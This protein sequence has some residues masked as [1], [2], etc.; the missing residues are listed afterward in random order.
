MSDQLSKDALEYHESYPA[1][2]L[3]IVATKPMETQRDLALAYSPGVAAAC[4]AIADN[5]DQAYRLTAK[6]NLVGVITNGSAVLGLGN[7]GALASKPVMEGKAVLFKKFSGIDVFD[8]E[9][10]QS[11]ADQFIETVASLEPTFGGINLEDIKAPECFE[12]ERALRERM[13]IPVFHDDQHGTAIVTTAAINSA[14]KLVNKNIEDVRLV[15]SGAGAAAL[16]CID[17]LIDLGLDRNKLLVLDKE[18]VVHSQRKTGIDKYKARYAIETSA[19]TMDD[20]I[21][22]ADIFLGCSAPGA[23]TG[24]QVAKMVEQ[25]IILA[26]ANPVPEIMPEVAYAA[27]PNV[28]MATGR[29]DYPNQVNN[30]LCFPFIFRGAMD[31]GAT[32]INKE[33]K[34]A[35]VNAL[36]TLAMK[37]PTEEVRAAYTSESLEFGPDYLIPK[38][39]DP[40]LIVEVA[41]A[42]AKAAMDSGV[43][44]RPIVDMHHYR[45][46][47]SEFVLKSSAVMYPIMER[48]R[49]KKVRLCYSEAED[50]RVL[51]TIKQVIES[52]IAFP[53]LVGN[54]KRILTLIDK[55]KLNIQPGVDCEIVNLGNPKVTDYYTPAYL[56]VMG[57]QGISPARAQHIVSSR[58]TV[59]SSLM[60]HNGDVDALLCGAIG[61]FDQ[62]LETVTELIGMRSDVTA[63]STLVGV[64]HSTGTYFICDTHIT[65][66]PTAEE[67]V[68]MAI[69]AAEEVKKFGIEP[70]IALVSH[71]NFGSSPETAAQK[72]SRATNL[73]REKTTDFEI[74]G[75]MSAEAALSPVFRD[76]IFPESAIKGKANLLIMPN[77]DAAHIAYTLMKSAA[78]ATVIGPILIGAARPVNIVTESVSVRGMVNMSAIAAVQA[79]LS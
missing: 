17:L 79:Q 67:L 2:K 64:I 62:R 72:M 76:R 33:M 10:D 70:K 44:T 54:E 11:N 57:R 37:L 45:Q 6:G 36:T 38:P 49:K 3:A 31:V 9:I 69:L 30:V 78:E 77:R 51:Q 1:G 15:V 4:E 24:E 65:Y 16:S 63:L 12:I 32:I 34:L 68:E 48:A 71:S 42:V 75:E 66:D 58:S 40:R 41:S 43:A 25:P 50:E 21:E 55:L 74:D 39:F 5:A 35:C 47:L 61:S 7:I 59:L 46:K 60:L 27:N 56:K 19:R 20:A 23:L 18:G 13:N 28:I 29:S 73:L 22:G 14:L 8:I 53:V 52:D 26:L